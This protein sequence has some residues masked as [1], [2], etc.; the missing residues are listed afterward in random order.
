M[1]QGA[2]PYRPHLLVSL[3]FQ[4]VSVNGGAID[5]ILESGN[6]GRAMTHCALGN[7][8]GRQ[9]L[10]LL[11]D[12]STHRTAS[13]SMAPVSSGQPLEEGRLREEAWLVLLQTGSLGS[14]L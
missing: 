10:H 7:M 5:E 3:G 13:P 2:H 11:S 4:L 12:S 1:L 8:S 14:T 6:K 9:G